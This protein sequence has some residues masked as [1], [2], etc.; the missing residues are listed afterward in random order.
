MGAT[1]AL[2][3]H[4]WPSGAVTYVNDKRMAEL[5]LAELVKVAAPP[6]PVAVRACVVEA[7]LQAQAELGGVPTLAGAICSLR[8]LNRLSNEAKHLW[9]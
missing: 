7:G 5:L 1:R 6:S 9:E 8:R 3:I 2:A 4:R